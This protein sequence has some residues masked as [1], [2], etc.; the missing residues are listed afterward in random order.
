MQVTIKRFEWNGE[1]VKQEVRYGLLKNLQKALQVY[2]TELKRVI[3][4]QSP[5]PRIHSNPGEPPLAQS[6]NLVNSIREQLDLEPSTQN[7]TGT[8]TTDVAYAETLEF[9]GILQVDASDKKYATRPISPLYRHATYVAPRPAWIPTFERLR[10]TLIKILGQRIDYPFES[11]GP[12]SS[13]FS[14][15]RDAGIDL[16]DFDNSGPGLGLI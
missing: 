10:E 15:V 16:S 7:I 12:S 3:G 2:S 11:F 13:T 8:V 5:H 9:G 14:D 1:K 4:V 6:R